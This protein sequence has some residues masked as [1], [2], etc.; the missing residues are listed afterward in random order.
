MSTT[1]QTG[2]ISSIM[3]ASSFFGCTIGGAVAN[4]FGCRIAIVVGGLLTIA[5]M[6]GC[7]LTRHIYQMYVLGALAGIGNGVAYTPAVVIVAQYF[8]KYYS[9]AAS[10]M[11]T[12]DSIGIML[13]GPLMQLFLDTYGWRGTLLVTGAV[14]ANI[15]VAG[16]VCRPNTRLLK[17]RESESRDS[18][19]N[20]PLNERGSL[21][22]QV[23]T[24]PEQTDPQPIAMSQS[25][26]KRRNNLC[27]HVAFFW[28]GVV[29]MFRLNLLCQSYRFSL[30]CFAQSVYV[31]SLGCYLIYLIPRATGSSGVSDREASFLL[32]VVGISGLVGRPFC[33]LLNQK[34]SSEVIYDVSMVVCACAVLVAQF[35]TYGHFVFS[36]AVFGF[37]IGFQRTISP[38]LMREY[39]GMDNLGS[40]VGIYS[41]IGGVVDLIGPILAGALYDAT[42]SFAI[43]FYVLAGLF[44]V[45]FLAM[46]SAPLLKRIEPGVYT[47][48]DTELTV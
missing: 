12:G 18:C 15:C 26:G 2:A 37:A 40:A 22:L 8:Q 43:L 3:S 46:L 44:V 6:I 31:A 38:V 29:K 34:V 45:G 13:F 39:V 36:A 7:A 14:T 16:A 30:F 41:G 10:F 25:S 19:R 27:V 42:E 1:A 21:E 4:R 9:L 32:S 17:A 35:G 48:V 20:I 5:G 28:T 47:S 11:T 33:G 23:I 24:H